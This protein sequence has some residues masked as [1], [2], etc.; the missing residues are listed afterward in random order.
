MLTSDDSLKLHSG[1]SDAR[2]L[3]ASSDNILKSVFG[4][5]ARGTRTFSGNCRKNICLKIKQGLWSPKRASIESM[6]SEGFLSP[7]PL[8]SNNVLALSVSESPKAEHKNDLRASYL[9]VRG[10]EA[11]TDNTLVAVCE[12]RAATT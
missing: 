5:F 9:L 2:I 1:L 8:R 12:S 6:S 7:N 4:E 3:S 10:G 11:I